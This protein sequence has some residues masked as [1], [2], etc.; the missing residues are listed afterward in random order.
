MLAR[1]PLSI[2]EKLDAGAVNQQVQG[3]IGA[4]IRDLNGERLL[5]TAQGRI[6]WH[7]PVQARQLQQA[8]NHPGRL[9]ERQLEQDLDRQTELDRSIREQRGA[10]G[11]AVMR[12][13][14]NHL[15]VQPDQ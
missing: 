1:L 12:R 13:E 2:A 3:A 10:T 4:P 8:G 15:L 7:R 11:A 6:V 5:P 14:P 9:P